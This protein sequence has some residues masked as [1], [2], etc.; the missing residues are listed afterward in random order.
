MGSSPRT[1]CLRLPGVS[2]IRHR[3]LECVS[4]QLQLTRTTPSPK[5]TFYA[6][7][8]DHGC[9]AKL[10]R[11]RE[12]ADDG[13]D[14]FSRI[15]ELSEEVVVGVET[16][17]ALGIPLGSHQVFIPKV[18]N[19]LVA[20]FAVSYGV[21]LLHAADNLTSG[22]QNTATLHY[23]TYDPHRDATERLPLT[24]YSMRLD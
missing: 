24:S 13:Q 9:A 3:H 1:V 18:D 11:I 15:E 12:Q 20:P 6:L 23:K 16:V 10:V 2:P 17:R 5:R 4:K 8:T 19:E 14:A 7:F 22:R 21:D